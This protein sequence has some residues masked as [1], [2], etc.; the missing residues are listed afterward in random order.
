MTSMF[1]HEEFVFWSV[2]VLALSCM[3]DGENIC[4]L[5]IIKCYLLLFLFFRI[6]FALLWLFHA[7]VARGQISFPTSLL[8]MACADVFR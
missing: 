7:V 6:I 1:N 2:D 3:W 5:H 8:D 4:I